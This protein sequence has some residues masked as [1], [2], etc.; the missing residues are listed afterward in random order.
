LFQSILGLSDLGDWPASLAY[1]PFIPGK[2]RL[3]RFIPGDTPY[4]LWSA[5]A[6]A[7]VFVLTRYGAQYCL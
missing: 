2:Y 5:G 6:L 4:E 3:T 7:C 1:P